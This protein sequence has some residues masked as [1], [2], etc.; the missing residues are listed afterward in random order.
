MATSLEPASVDEFL[1]AVLVLLWNVADSMFDTEMV[2]I[3]GGEDS[4]EPPL[5]HVTRMHDTLTDMNTVI[6]SVLH[7]FRLAHSRTILDEELGFWVLPRSTVWFSHFLF[8][9]YDDRRW[10]Q[11]FRFTKDAVFQMSA[12]LAPLCTR[13]DTKYRRALPMRVCVACTL[14]VLRVLCHRKI[15]RL[16]HR[17]RHCVRSDYPIPK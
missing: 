13:K 4:D 11:N 6:A 15:H 17:Q 12:V 8:H 16:R 9:E 7:D 10:V 14:L 5:R 2:A 3:D 1:P